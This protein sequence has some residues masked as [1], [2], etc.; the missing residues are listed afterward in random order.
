MDTSYHI[1]DSFHAGNGYSTDIHELLLTNDG[2]A[3]LM[4]YDPQTVDLSAIVPGGYP[5][6]T[7]IGLIVQELDAGKNVVFEWRS[8]DH[9]LITDTQVSL[10]TP[11]VDY[12]HGNAIEID[13]D[14]NLLI[15][16]RHLSEITKI[17]RQTGDIIW[18]LGGK[19]NQF[20]F[21]NDAAPYFHYQHD[22]RRLANG[23]ISLFDNRNDLMPLYSRATEYQIDEVGKVVTRTWEY[24]NTPDN[25]SPAMGD[26]QRLSNGNTMIGWG[27]FPELTEARADGTKAFEMVYGGSMMSYRAFR[28]V[29]HG[30]P[31]TPPLVT[32][33]K[34]LS[35]IM[36]FFSWNG[37][38]EIASYKLY[39]GNSPS[40][41]GLITTVL[42][43]GFETPY[44]VPPDST[45]CIYRVLPVD[46][47]SNDT[48]YS[49]DINIC[50]IY[51]FPLISR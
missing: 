40:P 14:G 20:S 26:A 7:V 23:R 15:S 48:Q 44:A 2:H 29:W 1:V 19:N 12:V 30:Y 3:L 34:D 28:F 9:F 24:R 18:R 22:I 36:L 46:G 21:V 27:T 8:W 13:N 16:S 10:T 51:Y 47:L 31:T 42:R 45:D 39:G 4:S 38:T 11:F 6:A 41:T 43:S 33:F 50:N 5:T 49:N 35:G 32:K 37:A 17:D 25:Y